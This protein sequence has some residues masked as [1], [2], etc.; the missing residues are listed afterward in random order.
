[1]TAYFI[2][3]AAGIAA[4]GFAGMT[5]FQLLLALGAPIGHMAWGGK[6]KKL[7]FSL[8]V[9]S[10]FSAMVF[11]FGTICV[12][13]RAQILDLLNSP[14]LTK[15]FVWILVVIFAMSTLGNISSTSKMEK[16][17]MTPIAIALCLTCLII[18]IFT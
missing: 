9:A 3:I 5:V 7:P 2:K 4:V 6:Y 8:R 18:A 13:E 11:V 16:R 17:V 1:M 10:F 15:I 12:L 14:V